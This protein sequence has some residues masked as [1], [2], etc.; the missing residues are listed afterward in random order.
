MYG[1]ILRSAVML[2]CFY[3]EVTMR[4]CVGGWELTERMPWPEADTSKS[5]SRPV[6][7]AATGVLLFEAVPLVVVAVFRLET[8]I[9]SGRF[10]ASLSCDAPP[11]AAVQ[12]IK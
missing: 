8:R 9:T 4:V 2:A 7:R 6:E 10:T 3:G 12:P 1:L 5:P 11:A